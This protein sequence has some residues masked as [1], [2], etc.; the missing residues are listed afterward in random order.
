MGTLSKAPR[1]G[2]RNPVNKAGESDCCITSSVLFLRNL[3]A[4]HCPVSGSHSAESEFQ[5][6]PRT[7]FL[8]G[9]RRRRLNSR[10]SIGMEFQP[11]L[12]Y[13]RRNRLSKSRGFNNGEGRYTLG[14]WKWPS[15]GYL[16]GGKISRKRKYSLILKLAIPLGK[17]CRLGC[18]ELLTSRKFQGFSHRHS[19]IRLSSPKKYLNGTEYRAWAPSKGSPGSYCRFVTSCSGRRNNCLALRNTL[20][21]VL[22]LSIK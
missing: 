7:D 16:A 13:G 19:L 17:V 5:K 3:N 4:A 8:P 10:S 21:R 11:A 12:S 6:C 1:R 2:H 20:K 9:V 15:A 22:H 18:E 14:T